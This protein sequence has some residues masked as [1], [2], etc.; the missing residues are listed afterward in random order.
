MSVVP[1]QVAAEGA[2]AEA[3]GR[4]AARV[5][6]FPEERLD[7]ALRFPVR[8]RTVDPRV[9]TLE[10]EAASRLKPDPRVVG[11]GVVAQH[12]LD[13]DALVS[14]PGDGSL[15][16][17]DAGRGV[18]AREELG[19]GEARVVVDCHL[20]VL[21]ADTPVLARATGLLAEYALAG[22][23][24]APEFLRST[25]SSSPGRARS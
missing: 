19:V 24:E 10:L 25:C 6:P 7:E 11:L 3:A 16:E 4:V 8:S 18:L 13:A 23:P 2:S 15:E 20:Q 22:L 5:G 21:P 9:A 12:A 14:V 1:A 17:A